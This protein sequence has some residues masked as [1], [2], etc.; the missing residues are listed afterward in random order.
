MKLEWTENTPRKIQ[1]F[2]G[3]ANPDVTPDMEDLLT[4]ADVEHIA[5]IFQT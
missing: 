1:T 4:G 2:A 3:A 5:E